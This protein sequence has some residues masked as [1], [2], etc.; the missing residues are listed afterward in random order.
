MT[1]TIVSSPP[2]LM[3]SDET[4]V[5][6]NIVKLKLKK[7]KSWNWELSTAASSPLIDFP[8]ILLYDTN[9]K[10]LADV[11][12]ADC[13]VN[14]DESYIT[15]NAIDHLPN[16]TRRS[17]SCRSFDSFKRNANS[18][19]SSKLSSSNTLKSSSSFST[20]KS[21]RV[22]FNIDDE[23]DGIERDSV[24]IAR[25]CKRSLSTN[26]S[27]SQHDVD[28]FL[29]DVVSQLQ[30][31]GY[32]CKVRRR[33]NSERYAN[34]CERPQQSIAT[35]QTN[36]SPAPPSP[37][38]A[39]VPIFIYSAKGLVRR[40]FN[41]KE[42]DDIRNR[43]KTLS[44]EKSTNDKNKSQSAECNEVQS[45]HLPRS[46]SKSENTNH[47]HNARRN[48]FDLQKSKSAIEMPH[49][50]AVKK[51]RRKA[52][53]THSVNNI[54]FSSS[55]LERLS[56]FKARSSSTD[57]MQ[58]FDDG[59]RH[60]VQ[61]MEPIDT[62]KYQLRTSAAG[63]LV[64][65]EEN[66]RNRRTRR[67][68]RSCGKINEIDEN[69]CPFEQ[70]EKFVRK[71]VYSGNECQPITCSDSN[72]LDDYAKRKFTPKKTPTY[73]TADKFPSRYE[74]AIANI[75]HLITNVILSHTDVDAAKPFGGDDVGDDLDSIEKCRKVKI[76]PT[77][78]KRAQF[79]NGIAHDQNSDEKL[80]ENSIS[81][82]IKS[83]ANNQ[84]PSANN[85]SAIV[86]S[87]DV[88]DCDAY[89]APSR[90]VDIVPLSLLEYSDAIVVNNN[91]RVKQKK[92]HHNR[93]VSFNHDD[94]VLEKNQ[95]NGSGN[96]D[97]NASNAK[98]NDYKIAR[99][100]QRSASTGSC[101][102]NRIAYTSSSDDDDSVDTRK[103]RIVHR[104][105]SKRVQKIPSIGRS[106][107]TNGKSNVVSVFQAKSEKKSN[108]RWSKLSASFIIFL[109]KKNSELKATLSIVH[110]PFTT[111]TVSPPTEQEKRTPQFD[112]MS[113]FNYMH[114]SRL[115][116]KWTGF[117]L[118][119][120]HFVVFAS[121]PRRN[122]HPFRVAAHHKIGRPRHALDHSSIM[123][124]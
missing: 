80:H 49:R 20:P 106:E 7:P 48:H 88:D 77:Q 113:V 37:S 63:T 45:S 44:A 104:R 116:Y 91:N 99:K 92:K 121:R 85:C 38:P 123:F 1:S 34:K 2:V 78:S 27:K 118:S 84:L 11:E 102:A 58:C 98:L 35:E 33:S 40:D 23:H 14:G 46:H 96:S 62:P 52:R 109:M 74:K 100:I 71:Y 119:P 41:A 120:S 114:L 65:R 43:E 86:H 61:H 83:D 59:G 93:K 26:S 89:S 15:T 57:S 56:A 73:S 64:V 53:R 21:G 95:F 68:P 90:A 60:F 122:V 87:H 108:L 19:H 25:K 69:A 47:L 28:G 9:D 50:L 22:T 29:E 112:L 103:K 5:A 18:R 67:R 4:A 3:P 72:L 16:G 24:K 105:R 36:G 115:Q 30:S 12:E 55:I 31:K 6:S 117:P 8:R 101:L 39:E 110:C 107:W 13:I 81:F 70:K 97:A 76:M 75:D 42:F 94:N 54:G 124:I 111:S 17:A 51:E 79:E 10:L 82:L 66:S 32:E